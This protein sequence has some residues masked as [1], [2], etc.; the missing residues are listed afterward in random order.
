MPAGSHSETEDVRGPARGDGP[1]RIASQD[2]RS[3]LERFQESP[4]VREGRA[5]LIGLEA[6]RTAL[7]PRWP[8]RREQVYQHVERTLAARAGGLGWFGR[9]S[10]DE[11]LVIRPD[12][13][14]C[15]VQA[16]CLGLARDLLGYFLG[17]AAP[18]EVDVREVVDLRADVL[19]TRK[20]DAAAV[21]REAEK[22]AREKASRQEIWFNP[23]YWSPFV[24]TDGREIRVSSRLEPLFE[25]RGYTQIGHRMVRKVSDVRTG[26][27]MGE[28]DLRRLPRADIERIDLA[29]IARGVSRARSEAGGRQPTL[30]L[31]VSYVTVSGARGRALIVEFLKEAARFVDKGLICEL[32]DVEGVPS[33][34]LLQAVA[35]VRPFCMLSVGRLAAPPTG[36]LPGLRDV[37]LAGLSFECLN[38]P[39]D[40][41]AFTVW[42]EGRIAHVLKV[43]RSAVVHGAPN[44]SYAALAGIAGATHASLRSRAGD[45]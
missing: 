32:L 13:S 40:H 42:V 29:T 25:L 31:P 28:A 2:L 19:S 18:D 21:L 36:P 33:S 30:M 26:A 7:G 5:C 45:V 9:V 27:V 34:A 4:T 35:L 44:A 38:A 37:G 8:G 20:L 6:V 22:E 11:F 39:D 14:P 23:D 1:A 16:A 15:G 12:L 43:T 41:A 10:E 3:A 24:A 17:D